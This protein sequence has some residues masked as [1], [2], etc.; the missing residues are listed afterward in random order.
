M[1]GARVDAR[2]VEGGFVV[3]KHN[4]GTG[5]TSVMRSKVTV[6]LNGVVYSA[7]PYKPESLDQLVGAAKLAD[8]TGIA[9]T[10]I[11]ENLDG[12]TRKRV[13]VSPLTPLQADSELQVVAGF[14][15]NVKSK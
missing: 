11:L 9:Q 8:R 7:P 6:N 2:G 1:T 12:V 13:S 10:V 15:V 3:Q 4:E 14:S 5:T